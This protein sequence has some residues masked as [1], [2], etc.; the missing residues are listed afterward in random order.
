MLNEA[1]QSRDYKNFRKYFKTSIKLK[2]KCKLGSRDYKS[3][4]NLKLKLKMSA[5]ILKIKIE[6]INNKNYHSSNLKLTNFFQTLV[7]KNK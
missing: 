5:L 7:E 4:I 6:W 3:I 1:K 2:C